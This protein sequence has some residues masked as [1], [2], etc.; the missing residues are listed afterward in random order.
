[1]AYEKQ[2]WVTGEVITKEK[3]NHMEDGIA[4]SGGVVT[5]TATVTTDTETGDDTIT[6]DDTWAEVRD[7][8]NENLVLLRFEDPRNGGGL[9]VDV[10]SPILS[11]Y[12][13]NG[14]YYLQMYDT[15]TSGVLTFIADAEDEQP[16]YQS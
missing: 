12:T 3:L 7:Y 16:S 1:M 9:I 4:N 5:I 15:Y 10:C 2:T 13:D 11:V 14:Q 6:L 8:F